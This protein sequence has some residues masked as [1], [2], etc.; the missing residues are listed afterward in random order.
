MPI[1][2]RLR[3]RYSN[4][5]GLKQVPQ[6][7]SKNLRG[8]LTGLGKILQDASI[9]RMRE[10]KG[11]EKKSLRVEVKGR[12]LDLR[13]HVY[14]VLI[15][16][17]IDALGRKPGEKFPP[18]GPG[19]KIFKWAR[20]R[21]KEGQSFSI[22]RNKR[23]ISHLSRRPNQQRR[24]A[25]I[26]GPQFKRNEKGKITKVAK[27]TLTSA[28]RKQVNDSH[29]K[30]MAFLAARSVYERGIKPSHWNKKALEANKGRIILEIRNALVRSVN[31][32]NRT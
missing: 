31:E 30:R 6:I 2:V 32:I 4:I 17:F 1:P 19:S 14:S 23:V 29:T 25:G 27:T 24:N 10:F 8:G 20:I 28:E 18:Y 22:G 21:F 9:R 16:A 13:L 7:L 12:I 5:D 26:R 11:D 3:V 15:Q